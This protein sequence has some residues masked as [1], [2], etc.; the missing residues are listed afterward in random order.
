MQLSPY[1]GL[2]GLRG[3]LMSNNPY[4]PKP[5]MAQQLNRQQMS[6]PDMSGHRAD[7][8]ARYGLT[9][10]ETTTAIESKG[11]SLAGRSPVQGATS[12][13]G[14]PLETWD[15]PDT[16]QLGPMIEGDR[17]RELEAQQQRM[18][19]MRSPGQRFEPPQNIGYPPNEEPNSHGCA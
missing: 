3:E 5:G 1:G 16:Q 15:S 9:D 10:E 19:D 13:Y 11:Q 2:G 7:V 4:Q 6:A 17:R 14:K 18:V 12:Y 8:Q